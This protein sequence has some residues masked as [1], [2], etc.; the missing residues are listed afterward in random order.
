MRFGEKR[1]EKETDLV[2]VAPGG[3]AYN[4]PLDV[5]QLKRTHVW[6]NVV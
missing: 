2:S 4:R 1:S 5:R 3:Q 6:N